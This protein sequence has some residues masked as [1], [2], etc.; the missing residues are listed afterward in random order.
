MGQI[1]GELAQKVMLQFD[2]IIN[3]SLATRVKTRMTFKV[4]H[5][6]ASLAKGASYNMSVD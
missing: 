5:H 3:H 4:F 2:R 6:Y 1:S